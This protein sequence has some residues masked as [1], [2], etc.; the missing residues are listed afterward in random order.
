ML[1]KRRRKKANIIFIRRSEKRKCAKTDDAVVGK[2]WR[3]RTKMH[4]G[5]KDDREKRRCRKKKGEKGR[6]RK[7]KKE[8]EEEE[9]KTG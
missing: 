6:R 1:A 9:E 7:L 3:T 8:E 5:M 2:V 4:R